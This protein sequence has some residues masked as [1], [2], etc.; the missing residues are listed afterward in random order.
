MMGLVALVA[1]V[2][3]KVQ[4]SGVVLANTTG[5]VDAPLAVVVPHTNLIK[6]PMT[7]TV[8]KVMI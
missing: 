5:L 2:A 6:E 8:K 1:A 4:I 7:E 3:L